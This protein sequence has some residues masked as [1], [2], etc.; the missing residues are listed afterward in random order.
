MRLEKRYAVMYMSVISKCFSSIYTHTLFWATADIPTAKDNTRSNNFSNKFDRLMQSMNYNETNG[1]CI[2]AEVS[3]IFAEIILSS[4]D[5][6]VIDRLG[7]SQITFRMD[8]EFRRYVDDYIIFAINQDVA[9][10]VMNAIRSG[11][12]KFNLHISEEKTHCIPRPFVTKTSKFTREADRILREFF[13]KFIDTGRDGVE[14]YNYPRRIR[15]HN[16][17]LRSLIESIKSSCFDHE[18]GYDMAANYVIGALV[19]RIGALIDGYDRGIAHESVN[20]DSY[21]AS[22]SLLLEAAYFFYTVEPSVPSSL[23]IAQAAVRCSDFFRQ[24]MPERLPFLAEQVVRWTFQFIRSLQG[25]TKHRD[26]NC[27]PLEALNILLILGEMGREEV[28][29]NQVIREFCDATHTLQYFEIVSILFCIGGDQNF[30]DL[31]NVL[32]DQARKIIFENEGVQSDAQG[33]HLALDILSCPYLSVERRASLLHDLRNKLELAQISR[34]E[35]N[36]AVAAFEERPWFVDWSNLSLLR[37]IR[38]K[39]LSAV[40]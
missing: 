27:V 33:A 24:R 17:L 14:S 36:A 3:R 25:T 20:E 2:G 28:L 32:F 1:I 13:E 21:I 23:R 8:Y 37:M 16:A 34:Q 15:R 30:E 31:R 5:A 22:L 26:T 12:A 10:K 4:V 18:A 11:L 38:K 40:Y 29:A 6:D 9:N 19:V 35:L 7:D 39:E